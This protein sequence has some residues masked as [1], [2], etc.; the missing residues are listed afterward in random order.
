MSINCRLP[1]VQALIF[2][3]GKGLPVFFWWCAK[4]SVL[5][6]Q[7][8]DR[9]I[10]ICKIVK[11]YFLPSFLCRHDTI[12]LGQT[13]NRRSLLQIYYSISV[14]S[15]KVLLKTLLNIL[16]IFK[17]SKPSFSPKPL[18]KVQ[19]KIVLLS[20]T[21]KFL[22]ETCQ[23]SAELHSYNSD[24]HFRVSDISRIETNFN[25]LFNALDECDFEIAANRK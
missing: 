24:S 23:R 9:L 21:R 10:V 22:L 20:K 7:A 17:Y 12:G 4:H 11:D 2:N 3:F 14:F 16:S 18:K 25:A 13:L 8:H 6:S 5:N 15:L 19:K 1:E